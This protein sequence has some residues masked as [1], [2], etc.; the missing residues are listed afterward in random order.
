MN[1]V[2]EHGSCQGNPAAL[3]AGRPDLKEAHIV[4]CPLVRS[5]HAPRSCASA[6][7]RE[8]YIEIPTGRLRREEQFGLWEDGR[9]TLPLGRGGRDQVSA[10]YESVLVSC[11]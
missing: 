11:S 9:P 5:R 6:V 8:Q 4:N 1:H 10:G 7:W 3:P 2:R